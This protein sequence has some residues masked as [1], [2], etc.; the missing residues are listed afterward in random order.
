MSSIL[1]EAESAF[2]GAMWNAL[3]GGG[4]E[5]P[6]L[7]REQLADLANL[8]FWTSLEEEEGRRVLGAVTLCQRRQ[9]PLARAFTHPVPLTVSALTRLLMASPRSSL[10]VCGGPEGL[11][12]WGL[13]DSEPDTLLRLRVAGLG[14]MQASLGRRV[15]ALL[16]RGVEHIPAASDE[17]ALNRMLLNAIGREYPDPRLD[18]H[19][20]KFTRLV[21]SCMLR[22]G[23]GGAL[24]VVPAADDTWREYVRFGHSFDEPA[25]RLLRDSVLALDEGMKEGARLYGVMMCGGAGPE[26]LE[27]LRRRHDE[28]MLLQSLT[29]SLSERVGDLSRVDGA[30][31]M[32]TDLRTLGFGAK[33]HFRQD[34]F[35]VTTVNGVTGDS[36][37]GVPLSELGGMR[38]QSAAR[39]VHTIRD[40][41]V[42]V[43]SQDGRLSLFSWSET[44]STV[45]VMQHLE[46]F[47]WDYRVA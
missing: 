7:G 30:V 27:D 4:Q 13:L 26:A 35:C 12:G 28:T 47:M 42:V 10:A 16:F 36:R 44:A 32:D 8:C 18:V 43:V 38:H 21:A 17:E 34:D 24:V 2:V 37:T 19:S 33:L 23:Q 9:A 1:F 39:F 29:Q 6:V 20:R 3:R 15:L 22:H 14:K 25:A 5:L 31:V 11:H 46:H 45:C 40:S 41:D